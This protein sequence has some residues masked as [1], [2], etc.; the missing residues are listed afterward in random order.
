MDTSAIFASISA[1]FSLIYFQSS[2][3]WNSLHPDTRKY[4]AIGGGL[5][6]AYY[7]FIY[8]G[9]SSQNYYPDSYSQYGGG[10]YG[11][12]QGGGGLSWTMWAAIMGAAYKL[13]PMFP[14]QLGEYARPFFGM[15]WTTF[16]WLLNMVTSNR[17]GGGRFGGGGYG[18][19]GFGGRRGGMNPLPDL[20]IENLN[21]LPY[22]NEPEILNFLRDR[23]DEDKVYSYFGPILIAFNPYKEMTELYSD[24]LGERNFHIF[25][26]LV[27][28]VNSEERARL[29]VGSVKD[30]SILNLGRT[31][32]VSQI[33]DSGD[34]S[35]LKDHMSSLGFSPTQIRHMTE[36][37]AGIL[38]CSSITFKSHFDSSGG[39]GCRVVDGQVL[40]TLARLIGLPEEDVN[41]LLTVR[42]ALHI[43]G[44]SFE[45][46]MTATH[47][48]NARNAVC[49]GL[50]KRLFEW[51]LGEVNRKVA[52]SGVTPDSRL[53]SVGILDIFGFTSQDT[54]GFDT[55]CVNYAAETLQQTLNTSIFDSEYQ[56]MFN[57]GLSESVWNNT[58]T[59]L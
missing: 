57:E 10:G 6:L 50:Y 47:A 15:S 59:A 55:L 11:Y 54:N 25:Y 22:L 18:G 26:Q 45:R 28:G 2:N 1:F 41:N 42:S 8:R 44:E 30:F 3:Y 33:D 43:R 29:G 35:V 52:P 24:L 7:F 34:F 27:A 5:L 16:M 17:G 56:L 9:S 38:H 4:I 37:V 20:E 13:P 51:L 32:H 12:G 53:A 46:K 49:M 40:S 48:V 58:K 19:G 36:G 14:D 21:S 31:S 23:F 39:E